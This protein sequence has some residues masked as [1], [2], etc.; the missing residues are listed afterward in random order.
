MLGSI[1]Q[2]SPDRIVRPPHDSF[3]AIHSAEIMAAAD[4]FGATDADEDVFVVIRHSCDFVGY[5]LTDRK[6][7][8]EPAFHQHAI[9]LHGPGEIKP[10]FCLFTHKGSGD[11]A[12]GAN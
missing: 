1:I 9:Q 11:F 2:N 6:D 12:E 7:Q 8:V 3:H 10:T 4:P 5:D